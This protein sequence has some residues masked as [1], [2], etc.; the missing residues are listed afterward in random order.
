MQPSP[1]C[2]QP[3]GCS[4][5][6]IQQVFDELLDNVRRVSLQSLNQISPIPAHG[7]SATAQQHY[8]A[9]HERALKQAADLS[10]TW[11]ALFADTLQVDLATSPNVPEAALQSVESGF[12]R[13]DRDNL[14]RVFN[15]HKDIEIP[16][17]SSRI[18]QCNMREAIR[19][20][21]S[22][23]SASALA[24]IP[25]AALSA[26]AMCGSKGLDFDEF[27]V[28]VGAAGPFERHI[29]KLPLMSILSD[30]FQPHIG[31][32]EDTLLRFSKLSES[33][34]ASATRAAT[35]GLLRQLKQSQ[36]DVRELFAALLKSD[37]AMGSSKF[38]TT[39]MACGGISDFHK[40]LTARIGNPSMDF[41]A[42]M[43]AEHCVK[44]GYDY[45][46]T[47]SNYSIT[48]TPRKEWLQVVGDGSRVRQAVPLSEMGHGREL[49]DVDRLLQLDSSVRAGLLECE[50]ISLLMYTGPM[51]EI[52]N[53]ILRRFPA[54]KFEVFNRHGNTFSTT[55]FVLVSAIQKLSQHMFVP[56]TMRL[57]RGFNSLDMPDSF[58]DTDENGCSGFVDWGFMSTSSNKAVAV[59][60]SGANEGK[61]KATVMV[62]HPSSVDRGASISEFSQ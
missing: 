52:Y 6:L 42:A 53:A 59:K 40:G 36:H 17:Q 33:E 13:R 31:D 51:F 56:Q 3:S 19:E 25:S 45:C 18:S 23:L 10:R 27:A 9:L 12:A 62:I 37:A 28:A 48:T 5:T 44:G 34:L 54:D 47:T 16:G 35:H 61:L 8:C 60:Y 14:L 49:K 43:R 39:K 20:M 7:T 57:Y 32:D 1:L 24:D 4:H 46:F 50:V 11:A 29:S 21:Y 2:H 15:A 55:I 41:L 38:Q 26:V 22:S 58:F 30:A